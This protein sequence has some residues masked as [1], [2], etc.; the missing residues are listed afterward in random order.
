MPTIKGTNTLAAAGDR[1]NVMQGS[2]YEFLNFPA[3]VEM[4]LIANPGDA[5]TAVITTGSDILL[6]NGVLD[7]KAVTLPL[8]TDDIQF[9]DTVLPG[10]RIVVEITATAAADVV[11]HLIKITP[12]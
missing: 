1:V 6:S 10:E 3:F 7:E 9:T 2:Q 8:T 12:L 4:A 5:P 11:R